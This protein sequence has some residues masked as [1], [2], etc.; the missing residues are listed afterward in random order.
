MFRFLLCA[1]MALASCRS[2]PARAAFDEK[3]AVESMR[4][5]FES[6]N[7]L[8]LARRTDQALDNGLSTAVRSLREEAARL[9]EEADRYQRRGAL[10]DAYTRRSTAGEMLALAEDV[11]TEW[12]G[13]FA[14][15]LVQM[16]QIL[17]AAGPA[18]D[19]PELYEPMS[20]WLRLRLSQIEAAIGTQLYNVLHLDDL[21]TIN[22]GTPVV[23]RLKKYMGDQ[24]PTVELYALY[25][26][27]WA[28]VVAY[29]SVW[30]VCT[31]ATWGGGWSVICTP[32]AMMAEKVM[33]DNIAPRWDHKI[34][35]RLYK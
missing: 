34:W 23:L 11:E 29:W 9:N 33:R 4:K 6:G 20:R 13:N 31:A 21:Q 27:P 35:A 14:G 24:I 5:E 12:R 19:V 22:E 8:D 15:A 32:A 26:D 28:G 30:G 10:S 7:R 16:V 17:E 2:E 1:A 25:F 18:Q 3:P